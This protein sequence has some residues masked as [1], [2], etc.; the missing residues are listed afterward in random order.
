MRKETKKLLFEAYNYCKDNNKSTEY[1]LDY[2]Q[3]MANVDLDCVLRFL[4]EN[5]KIQEIIKNT[6][7][8]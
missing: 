5:N 8:R 3:D 6:N 7:L 2:I 4:K 1:M